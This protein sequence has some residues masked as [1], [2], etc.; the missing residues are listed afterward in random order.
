MRLALLVLMTLDLRV[1]ITLL[2]CLLTAGLPGVLATLAFLV[3]LR[4]LIKLFFSIDMVSTRSLLEIFVPLTLPVSAGEMPNSRRA[5]RK[6]GTLKTS[7]LVPK[8]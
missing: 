8:Y 1:E 3:V 2:I 4:V 5:E 6:A 7:Q